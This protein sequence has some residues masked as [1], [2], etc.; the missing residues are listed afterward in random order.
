MLQLFLFLVIIL[1]LRTILLYSYPFFF[2]YTFGVCTIRNVMLLNHETNVSLFMNYV[3]LL[4]NEK[5]VPHHA[6]N[7]TRTFALIAS[8]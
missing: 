1:L 8:L 4:H 2:R 3:T 5:E 7:S 6:N